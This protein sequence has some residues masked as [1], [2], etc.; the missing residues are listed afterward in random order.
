MF[1][2]SRSA[3]FFILFFFVIGDGYAKN[4]KK[5]KPCGNSCIAQSKTCRKG[6]GSSSLY[7][8]PSPYKSS[9]L[10]RKS[11]KKRGNTSSNYSK[12]NHKRRTTSSSYVAASYTSPRRLT[13]SEESHDQKEKKASPATV[14]SSVSKILDADIFKVRN[15][16]NKK[17]R[18]YGIDAP[19]LDQPF[20]KE[21]KDFLTNYIYKKKVKVKIYD[22]DNGVNSAVVFANKKNVNEIM[23]KSGY[24]WVSTDLCTESFCDDWARYEEESREQKKGLWSKSG[25]IAPW[26]WR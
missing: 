17:I 16:K 25:R 9:S 10:S 14:W 23:V 8:Y 24:A 11:V 6:L 1:I 26:I 2:R 20:G 12:R 7:D 18:L 22:R 3:F 4:C 15:K 19:E 21:A 13:A 5:G